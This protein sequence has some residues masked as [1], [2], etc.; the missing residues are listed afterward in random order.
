[1][2]L[3]GAGQLPKLTKSQGSFVSDFN[4]AKAEAEDAFKSKK[5]KDDDKAQDAG[6]KL[7]HKQIV[8]ICFNHH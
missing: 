3:F 7:S 4:S 6:R 8:L 1:V 2:L 5:T